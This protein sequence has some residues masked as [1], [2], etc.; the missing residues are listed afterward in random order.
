MGKGFNKYLVLTDTQLD[1]LSGG[2][3]WNNIAM[4]SLGMRTFKDIHGQ[5][6]THD[7]DFWYT[8]DD[9]DKHRINN[10]E[11]DDFGKVAIA[12]HPDDVAMHLAAYVPLMVDKDE[13]WF[14]VEE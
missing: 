13:T 12:V 9:Y 3:D 2:L 8:A 5:S 11:H 10:P 7:V 4:P 1:G 14:I 6:K